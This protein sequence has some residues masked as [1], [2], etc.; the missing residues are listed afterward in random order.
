MLLYH[1]CYTH[2]DLLGVLDVSWFSPWAMLYLRPHKNGMNCSLAWRSAKGQSSGGYLLQL[3]SIEPT[4]IKENGFMYFQA[5]GFT[6]S[7]D[8]E[9]G[10]NMEGYLFKKTKH[11]FKAWVRLVSL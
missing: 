9:N 5:I 6:A 7:V 10:A 4:C 3:Q 8:A 1:D 2:I 11:A